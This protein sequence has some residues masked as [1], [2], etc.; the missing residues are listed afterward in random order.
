MSWQSF[1]IDDGGLFEPD[2]SAIASGTLGQQTMGSL[3]LE[4]PLSG[5]GGGWFSNIVA[6][7]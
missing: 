4:F 5:E 3:T 2:G 1:V 7:W 6:T